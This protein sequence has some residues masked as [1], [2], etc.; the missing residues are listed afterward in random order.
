M[1]TPLLCC[2]RSGHGI[3]TTTDLGDFASHKMTRGVPVVKHSLTCRSSSP[4]F[5]ILSTTAVQCQGPSLR[6]QAASSENAHAGLT[7]AVCGAWGGLAQ[8]ST[9]HFPQLLLPSG[10]HWRHCLRQCLQTSAG[11]V[12]M[13]EGARSLEPVHHGCD[14][15]NIAFAEMQ[16]GQLGEQCRCRHSQYREPE[17]GQRRRCWSDQ[18][19]SRHMQ[20]MS[21]PHL[22]APATENQPG[23]IC[24]SQ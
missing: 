4:S 9:P 14:L 20:T 13:A 17:T 12:S 1:L 24:T 19:C 8:S 21:D 3:P 2:S 23:V 15:Q 22:K 6:Q 7:A 18:P 5:Q 16:S 10:H 11:G